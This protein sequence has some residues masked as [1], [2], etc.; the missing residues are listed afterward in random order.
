V[1]STLSF[2]G[3]FF[4]ACGPAFRGPVGE[5][6]RV[7]SN[8]R[9]LFSKHGAHFYCFR[10]AYGFAA[11]PRRPSFFSSADFD[12]PPTSI[13]ASKPRLPPSINGKRCIQQFLDQDHD[14]QFSGQ[15]AKS[16]MLFA[17]RL[18][19]AYQAGI[20]RGAVHAHK[21]FMTNPALSGARPEIPQEISPPQAPT[22]RVNVE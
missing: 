22:Q 10:R 5:I 7:K 11:I 9:G 19:F 13:A 8:C 14:R 3:H 12:A 21:Y 18:V 20:R 1:P 4:A 15:R 6:I 16:W 2:R 17:G